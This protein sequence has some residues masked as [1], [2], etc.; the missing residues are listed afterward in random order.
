MANAAIAA[1]QNFRDAD[2]LDAEFLTALDRDVLTTADGYLTDKIMSCICPPILDRWGDEITELRPEDSEIFLGSGEIVSAD[3]Y[4]ADNGSLV[5]A[6][7]PTSV[8]KPGAPVWQC[9]FESPTHIAEFDDGSAIYSC[10][11]CATNS[12]VRVHL[13]NLTTI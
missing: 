3:T 11:G 5:V 6:R 10:K 4:L 7:Y 13:S 1:I 12:P 2:W 9:C 8:K